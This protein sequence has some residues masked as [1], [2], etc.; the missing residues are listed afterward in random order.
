MIPWLLTVVPTSVEPTVIIVAACL[1]TLRPVFLFFKERITL[2]YARTGSSES[3]PKAYPSAKDYQLHSVSKKLNRRDKWDTRQKNG[4][5]S[6]DLSTDL[7]DAAVRIYSELQKDSM[8]ARIL[9]RAEKD[10]HKIRK[11]V[12]IDVTADGNTDGYKREGQ[13]GKDH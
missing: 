3:P 4:P 12:D 13:E 11:T 10:Q 8:E 9:P 1:P 6:T 5:Y 7:E 2:S